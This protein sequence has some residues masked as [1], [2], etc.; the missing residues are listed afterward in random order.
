MIGK[1]TVLVIRGAGYIGSHIV[2]ELLHRNY[3]VVVLDNL[4]TGHR[5]LVPGG[6]FIEGDLGDPALLGAQQPVFAST[7]VSPKGSLHA[8]GIS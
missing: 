1:A 5:D 7:D 2:Q 3:P 8:T 4:S 6:E